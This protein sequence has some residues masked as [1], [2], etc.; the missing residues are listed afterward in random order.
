VIITE[1]TNYATV[2]AKLSWQEQSESDI[3][4]TLLLLL[5]VLVLILYLVNRLLSQYIIKA[6]DS[7]YCCFYIAVG[8]IVIVICNTPGRVVQFRDLRSN[9]HYMTGYKY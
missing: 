1:N 4:I 9:G 3:P 5:F 8:I 7:Y 2:H 6:M